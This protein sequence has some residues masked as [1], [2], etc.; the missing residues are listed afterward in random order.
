[1]ARVETK[2]KERN[3]GP[4]I[5]AVADNVGGDKKGEE[6][7]EEEELHPHDTKLREYIA[8]Q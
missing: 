2:N 6:S 7:P 4:R 8:G 5:P 3:D 1:L